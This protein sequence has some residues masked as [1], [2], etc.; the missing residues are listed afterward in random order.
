MVPP[1]GWAALVSTLGV[2][3]VDNFAMWGTAEANSTSSNG[4]AAVTP[5]GSV[6]PREG[7]VLSSAPCDHPGASTAWALMSPPPPPS[8]SSGNGGGDSRIQLRQQ[9]YLSLIHI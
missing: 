3:Q 8:S 1:S 5:C 9:S 6:A 4:T 2:T 7:M